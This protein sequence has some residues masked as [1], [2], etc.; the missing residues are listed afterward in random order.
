MRRRYIRASKLTTF[1]NL[2][3]DSCDDRE[4]LA[5]G[6]RGAFCGPARGSRGLAIGI[7]TLTGLRPLRTCSLRT[8][9]PAFTSAFFCRMCSGSPLSSGI[10]SHVIVIV[11]RCSTASHD[12]SGSQ[13]EQDRLVVFQPLAEP[14][15]RL[16]YRW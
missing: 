4:W 9:F 5:I 15:G 3:S 7:V 14:C 8:M 2:R 11:I 13:T 12:T 1:W 6:H 10:G 16:G